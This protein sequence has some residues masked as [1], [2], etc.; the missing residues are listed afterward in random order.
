MA[1]VLGYLH[2]EATLRGR[3]YRVTVDLDRESWKIESLRPWSSER[4]DREFGHDPDLRVEGGKLP[5]GVAFA[6]LG[7]EGG[8]QASGQAALYFM[9]E[10]NLDLSEITLAGEQHASVTLRVD[11]LTGRVDVHRDGG[12]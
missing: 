2:D 5:D 3:V 8:R 1:A 11:G 9:P 10:G 6:S 7:N 4:T 12:R